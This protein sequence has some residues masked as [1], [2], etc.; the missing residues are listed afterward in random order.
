MS[1]K[2]LT[3]IEFMDTILGK[4]KSQDIEP[5]ISEFDMSDYL[6]NKTSTFSRDKFDTLIKV[7]RDHI[8]SAEYK[9]KEFKE[10]EESDDDIYRIKM[11]GFFAPKFDY[12]KLFK[13][14]EIA[15]REYKRVIES[16][17]TK[18]ENKEQQPP[19]Q[20]IT[21][22]QLFKNPYNK[23]LE[24]FKKNLKDINLIDKNNQWRTVDNNGKKTPTKDIGKFYKWL[25]NETTVFDKT[26]DMTAHCICFCAEFG[27]IAY[28]ETK[29][30]PM[31]GRKVTAKLIREADNYSEFKEKYDTTFKTWINKEK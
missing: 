24:T 21:F 13:F 16:T 3:I 4:R 2:D 6:E 25:Y 8:K 18:T 9:Y 30:K 19:K 17:S 1:Y 14:S 27:I 5:T 10:A 31:T 12:E 28:E 7:I 20:S 15:E 29:N 11:T 23:D 22:Y 26:S